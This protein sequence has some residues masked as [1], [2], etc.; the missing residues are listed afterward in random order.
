MSMGYDPAA[1][2]DAFEQTLVIQPSFAMAHRDLGMLLLQQQ[3]FPEAASHLEKA[4]ELGIDQARL[5]NFLGIA[6][7]RTA[8][9]SAAA[10]VYKKALAKDPSYAEAHLNLSYAY[11]KLNRP[12]DAKA[13]YQAACKLD[14]KLCQYRPEK[15][16]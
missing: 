11:Q 3:R 5:Y 13:E 1:A 4:A 16:Q 8:R 2:A 9:F 6:Y 15:I 12:A 14:Q 10:G 7:S